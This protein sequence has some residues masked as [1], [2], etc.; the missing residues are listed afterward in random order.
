MS[1]IPSPVQCSRKSLSGLDGWANRK[2]PVPAWHDSSG[3][4]PATTAGAK[5]LLL[6]DPKAVAEQFRLKRPPGAAGR[7]PGFGARVEIRETGRPF[8][9]LT[10]APPQP[11]AIR[12]GDLDTISDRRELSGKTIDLVLKNSLPVP[13]L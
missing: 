5:S 10:K 7:I 8:C 6:G 2:R 9:R 11:P 12:P 3:K 4:D 1:S 13:I